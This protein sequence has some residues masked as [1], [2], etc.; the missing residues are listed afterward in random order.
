M[1]G[2]HAEEIDGPAMLQALRVDLVA[3]CN[4]YYRASVDGKFD[5]VDYLCIRERDQGWCFMDS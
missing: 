5:M 4:E 1:F 2:F 3:H